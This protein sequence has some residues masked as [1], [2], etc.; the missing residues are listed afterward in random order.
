MTQQFPDVVRVEN[1]SKVFKLHRDTSIKERIIRSS[2]KHVEEFTALDD[3]SVSIPLNSTVGLMGHNGSG[4]S[5]LLK[6][7]GS[8]IQPTTGR[9]TTRGRMAALLELGA[10]FHQDLTGR[11]NVFLNA[12]ILG[13]S[14]KETAAKFDEIV[15]FS[16]IEPF[17]DSQVKFYSSGMYVRLA[18]AV[19]VHS[20]PDVLLV[21]EVLAVGD[22]PFQRKCMDKIREFQGEGRSIV[23]VSHSAEQVGSVC[24]RGIVL[25]HGKVVYDGETPDAIHILRE[26]FEKEARRLQAGDAHP[27]RGLVTIDRVEVVDSA[28]AP[29][30]TVSTGQTLSAR[31]HVSSTERLDHWVAA[32]SIETNLGQ[33]LFRFDSKAAGM[34]LPPIDGAA[35]VSFTIPDLPLGDGSFRINVGIGDHVGRTLDRKAGAWDLVVAGPYAGTGPIAMTPTLSVSK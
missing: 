9:V 5:T 29:A 31:I 3:V 26:G 11:E 1:V 34:T 6:V 13:M 27:G 4:K 25:D 33:S 21:D 17:I 19:A 14:K 18:F 15:A 12:S 30:H 2:R 35:I 10:G 8:I 22:E 24:D 23:L 20:D 28:G 7:M 32:F 16:G